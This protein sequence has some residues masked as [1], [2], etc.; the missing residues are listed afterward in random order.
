VKRL[1]VIVFIVLVKSSLNAQIDAIFSDNFPSEATTRVGIVADYDFNSNVLTNTLI[2]KFYTGGFID[3]NLKASSYERLKNK[4]RVG[5]NVNYGF[6]AAYKPDSIS[7]KKYVSFFVS[8]RDRYHF[9]SHFSKDFFKLAFYGNAPFAGKTAYL[10]NFSLNY[11]HYQQL[12]LGIYSSNLDSVACWGIGVS[13]L[14]GQDYLSVQAPRAELFTSEDGDYITFDTQMQFA[15]ADTATS[16]LASVDGLG[17]SLDF[18]F[19]APF[20]TRFG[21]AKIKVSLADIGFIRFNQQTMVIEQDSTFTYSGVEVNSLLNIQNSNQTTNIIDSIVKVDKK[22]FSANL[23]SVFN[24][25][26]ESQ[27]GTKFQLTEGMRYSFNSNYALLAYLKGSYLVTPRFMVSATVG[28]GGY[29]GYGKFN[30]GLGIF[31]NLKNGL[32]IYAGSNNVE[33]YLAPKTNAGQGVYISIAKN[34][35]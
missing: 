30:Y 18:Y 2:S 12:Q 1:I 6:Y 4:N 26:Y 33:G 29:G 13:L 15:T 24:L 3:D 7:H 20:Q 11:L 34:F 28:Y 25:M 21:S 19:E 17:A 23:P 9:D 5:G 31:A 10:N 14:K 22:G 32:V 16:G 8:M 27:L 35:R